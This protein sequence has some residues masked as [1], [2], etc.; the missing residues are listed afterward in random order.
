MDIEKLKKQV[1]ECKQEDEYYNAKYLFDREVDQILYEDEECR[2]VM[3][4]IFKVDEE[5]LK[6]IL[7]IDGNSFPDV[8]DN[9]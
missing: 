2:K 9:K 1:R 5:L 8:D 4:N 6:H 3:C 7:M